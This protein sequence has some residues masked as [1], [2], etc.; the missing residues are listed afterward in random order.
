MGPPR[1]TRPKPDEPGAHASP[2]LASTGTTHRCASAYAMTWGNS[3]LFGFFKASVDYILLCAPSIAVHLSRG[4]DRELRDGLV[5][6][7]QL[8]R[9]DDRP[10]G[11]GLRFAFQLLLLVLLGDRKSTVPNSARCA[12]DHLQDPSVARPDQ[13]LV[14]VQRVASLG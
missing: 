1:I 14:R 10:R 8:D 4:A 5:C 12:P 6:I 7:T 3:G 9:G 13:R 2:R 11:G